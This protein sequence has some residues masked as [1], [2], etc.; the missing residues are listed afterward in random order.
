MTRW[1]WPHMFVAGSDAFAFA[2]LPEGQGA[3]P[4][5]AA[6]APMLPDA[7]LT[8][9]AVAAAFKQQAFEH[10]P[11]HDAAHSAAAAETYPGADRPLVTEAN[12]QLIVHA[13]GLE[14]AREH[15]PEFNALL[16]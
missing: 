4:D 16:Y 11:S 9:D 6:T 8:Y 1:T 12:L 10:L 5:A 13:I 15:Y 3:A 2:D 14:Q 7:S